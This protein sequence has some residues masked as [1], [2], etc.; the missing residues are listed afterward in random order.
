MFLSVH[1]TYSV[2]QF[3][4]WWLEYFHAG[5]NLPLLPW[6]SPG[7]GLSPQW[8]VLLFQAKPLI[9]WRAPSCKLPF[10]PVRLKVGENASGK[11]SHV[12]IQ[13]SSSFSKTNASILFP[14]EPIS[15]ALTWWILTILTSWIQ[16]NHWP[17]PAMITGSPLSSEVTWKSG[18]S[19]WFS[20][21]TNRKALH[22]V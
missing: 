8:I 6:K 4:S 16:R 12:L 14:P 13:K 20:V 2:S 17:L 1:I 22:W 5:K 7:L 21:R 10:L 19:T 18:H 9:L 3:I 11:K 15:S